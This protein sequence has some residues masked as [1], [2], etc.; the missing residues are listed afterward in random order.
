MEKKYTG[1]TKK[2]KRQKFHLQFIPFNKI[3]EILI[4]A[5]LLWLNR[6][7]KIFSIV[8]QG[9]Y[10]IVFF[11][12]EEKKVLFYFTWEHRSVNWYI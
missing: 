7:K 12:T 11:I 10:Q 3:E 9:T 1:Y 4:S 5:N 8:R 6:F 2:I